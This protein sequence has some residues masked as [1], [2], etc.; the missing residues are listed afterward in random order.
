MLTAWLRGRLCAA[1]IVGGATALGIVLAVGW[2]FPGFTR[3]AILAVEHSPGLA[4][5]VQAFGTIGAILGTS[6]IARRQFQR[7]RE[8]DR[9]A[10]VS[11]EEHRR[12]DQSDLIRSTAVV[13][14]NAMGRVQALVG[15]LSQSPP[16]PGVL[17]PPWRQFLSSLMR[18]LREVRVT[19]MR[20]EE[21][22]RAFYRATTHL[23]ILE[24][25]LEKAPLDL[26]Q[27]NA[28]ARERYLHELAHRLEFGQPDLMRAIGEL[29]LRAEH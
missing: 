19:D 15:E 27:T 24:A 4:A 17:T 14:E 20:D 13:L 7:E 5:W 23:E 21:A 25:A 9:E 8:R 10:E 12:R 16:S 6:L 3:A 28:A 2:R 18:S 29:R 1:W 11:L 22:I 26:A